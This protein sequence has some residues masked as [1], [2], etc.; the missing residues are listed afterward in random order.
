[1]RLAD[2]VSSSSLA[3]YIYVE[4]RRVPCD[5]WLTRKDCSGSLLCVCR[6]S[7]FSVFFSV[8]LLYWSPIH[9]RGAI[10]ATQT[11]SLLS[12]FLL[13]ACLFSSL[14][15]ARRGSFCRC[16]VLPAS[17]PSFATFFYLLLLTV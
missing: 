4:Q 2:L 9:K 5:W 7:L 16:C 13:F 11:H 14:R 3:L 1:V 17:F 15:A 10:Q 6:S 12:L 8:C